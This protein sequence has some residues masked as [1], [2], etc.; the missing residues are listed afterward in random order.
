M[1]MKLRA[2]K[3][4]AQFDRVFHEGRFA[5]KEDLVCY[6]LR[7]DAEVT[8]VGISLSA[9]VGNAVERN[10]LRRRLREIVNEQ[11]ANLAAGWDVVLLVRQPV[12]AAFATLR[13]Q[14]LYLLENRELL[15]EA[16]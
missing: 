8:R 4:H 12:D 11:A 9:R 10:R 5:V 1:M 6:C 3:N 14:V 2:L 7:N 15:K 13:K 16:R